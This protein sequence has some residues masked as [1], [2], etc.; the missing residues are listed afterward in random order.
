MSALHDEVLDR[1]TK[2]LFTLMGLEPAL[3]AFYLAG[4]RRWRF[5]WGTGCRWISICSPSAPGNRAR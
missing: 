2:R 4:G 1:G 5:S 3:S